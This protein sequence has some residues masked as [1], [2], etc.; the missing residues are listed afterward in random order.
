[1]NILISEISD[2]KQELIEYLTGLAN[3]SIYLSISQEDTLRIVRDVSPEVVIFCKHLTKDF[4]FILSLC[5]LFPETAVYLYEKEEQNLSWNKLT[6]IR[7]N[8]R[9]TIENILKSSNQK[10]VN[11]QNNNR[12]SFKHVRRNP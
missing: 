7:T 3:V 9:T 8:R 10:I 12:E 4:Q 6:D 5:M 2:L 1:M 11:K